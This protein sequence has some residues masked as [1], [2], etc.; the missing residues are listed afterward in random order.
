MFAQ[1]RSL[2]VLVLGFL[3]LVAAVAMASAQVS[4][5]NPVSYEVGT[6]P[7]AV[8]VGDFN[9]DGKMDLAVLNSGNAAVGDDGGVSILLGNGDGTLQ[10]ARNFPAGQNPITIVVADFNHD[11]KLDLVVLAASNTVVLLLGNGDGTFQSPSNIPI[12]SDSVSHF[13][14]G[15]LNGDGNADLALENSTAVGILLSNGDGTFQTEVDYS[16]VDG[17]S[18]VPI[19]MGDFNG[20]KKLDVALVT[21]SGKSIGLLLGNGDGTLQ[22]PT[23]K[24]SGLVFGIKTDDFNCDGRTDLVAYGFD[25]PCTDCFGDV[26]KT[27]FLGQSDGTIMPIQTGPPFFPSVIGD[28]DGDGKPDL[29]VENMIAL[30]NGDGTFQPLLSVNLLLLPGVSTGADLNGDGLLDGVTVDSTNNLVNVMLN[31][32]PGFTLV[33]SPSTAIVSAG[34]PVTYTI[35]V[36]QQNGFNNS[37]ALACSAPASVSIQCSVSPSSALP[38][39]NTKLTVTTTGMSAPL[40]FPGNRR[41]T[42]LFGLWLPVAGFAV[43]GIGVGSPS[44]RRTKRLGLLVFCLLFGSLIFLAGCAGASNIGEGNSATPSGNYAITVTGTSGSLQRSTTVTLSVQ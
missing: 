34:G 1:S 19:I 31:T 6:A 5:A 11:G 25:K 44:R 42:V 29:I 35:N 36:G 15:D 23:Y 33:P 10:A 16:I 37:A 38:G 12:G 32:T 22:Q 4:F 7:G 2:V 26:W 18:R 17:I 8:A 30:G 24:S 3:V 41:N 20:D 27:I 14:A 28:V 21:G 43:F 40:G 13:A 9:G 39:T